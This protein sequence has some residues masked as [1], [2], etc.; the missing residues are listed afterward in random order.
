[1]IDGVQKAIAGQFEAALSMLEECVRACPLAEWEGRIAKYPF[2][3]VA[4]HTLCMVDLYLS[5]S[6]GEF[7]TRADLHPQGWSEI[8]DEYPS[9]RFERDELLKYLAICREKLRATIAG[10]TRESLEGPSGQGHLPITRL[11][12]HLYNLRH[13]Q[14]HAGQLSAFLRRAGVD[15]SWVKSGER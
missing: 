14:H 15:T 6:E 4:Y 8:N 3:L 13:A 11:E 1:M 9:R 5:A 2:W 7:R 10:E 12:L